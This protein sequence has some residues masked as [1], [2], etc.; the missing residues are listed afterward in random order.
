MNFHQLESTELGFK[1]KDCFEYVSTM[2]H[3]LPTFGP[4]DIGLKL[5]HNNLDDLMMCSMVRDLTSIKHIK[6]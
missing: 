2:E 4:Q 5:I 3:G 6:S 1:S